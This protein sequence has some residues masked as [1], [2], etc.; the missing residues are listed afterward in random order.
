MYAILSTLKLQI[1]VCDCLY[2]EPYSCR[3]GKYYMRE[4]ERGREGGK[5]GGREGG[6]ERGRRVLLGIVVTTSPTCSL[7]RMVV[8]PAP[9]SPRMSILNSFDPQRLENRLEKKLPADRNN[10]TDYTAFF[11]T[12][13]P[14]SP[15][16]TRNPCPICKRTLRC[17]PQA[18]VSPTTG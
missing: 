1:F 8:L 15:I 3:E 5:E 13:V 9:S 16:L 6:R 7:Y 2:I 11:E 10:S 4:G 17:F 18:L 12:C 14:Y